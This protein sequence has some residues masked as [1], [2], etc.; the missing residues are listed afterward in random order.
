MDSTNSSM[1]K[2]HLHCL[3]PPVTWSPHPSA[4]VASHPSSCE[5]SSSRSCG[6]LPTL[7]PYFLRPS[8][9]T[10]MLSFILWASRCSVTGHYGNQLKRAEIYEGSQLTEISAHVITWLYGFWAQSEAEHDTEDLVQDSCLN[11]GGQEA[12]REQKGHGSPNSL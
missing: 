7:P 11:N 8:L 1:K 6:P 5:A 9:L 4:G 12:D 2:K 10:S 3:R